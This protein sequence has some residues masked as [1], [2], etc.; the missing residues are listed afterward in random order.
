MG[1]KRKIS[2][3]VFL[4]S[5]NIFT[6]YEYL[7]FENTINVAIDYNYRYGDSFIFF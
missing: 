6:L 4:P 3:K 1:R 2:E 7:C 5:H